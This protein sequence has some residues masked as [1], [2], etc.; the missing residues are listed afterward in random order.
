MKRSNNKI[1]KIFANP[2][3]LPKFDRFA[4]GVSL[5]RSKMGIIYNQKYW[6]IQDEKK[7]C[8]T[9]IR[10]FLEGDKRCVEVIC[11]C[12]E[13]HNTP[14]M[15]FKKY[16][17][18]FCYKC[19]GV[20]LEGQRFGRLVVLS[21]IHMQGHLKWKCLCDCGK[22]SYPT[23]QA[24][25]YG[26]SK[27]CGCYN[28][29]VR[30]EADRVG[31]ISKTFWTLLRRK[32]R[33]RNIGVEIN[34]IDAWQQ[35]EKQKGKCALSGIDLTFSNCTRD[36][37]GTASIDRIDSRKSYTKDNIQW[38]HKNINIMKW[39]MSDDTFIEFCRAVANYQSQK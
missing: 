10:E 25:L 12:G 29:E 5:F 19:R 11:K 31:L 3:G 16:K 36:Y 8:L 14:I 32:A 26:H 7:G 28:S 35:F 30:H 38:V 15:T 24:L 20:K 2:G 37:S 39:D 22:M 23:S 9:A 33:K 4:P 6:F 1:R 21:K 27:S 18:D 13:K 17:A 34:R